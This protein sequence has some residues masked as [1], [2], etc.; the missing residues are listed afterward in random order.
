VSEIKIAISIPTYNGQVNIDLVDIFRRAHKRD[1]IKSAII[2]LPSS[3]IPDR[4]FNMHWCEALGA[5]DRGDAT[6]W[7]KYDP[8]ISVNVEFFIDEMVS[9]MESRRADIVS[10][11]TPIKDP[12]FNGLTSLAIDN[13][14]GAGWGI[15]RR[16][17]MD[18]VF[19]LPETFGNEICP[20][21]RLLVNNSLLLVDLRG[22]WCDNPEVKW[23]TENSIGRIIDTEGKIKRKVMC[24]PQDWYFSRV[25]QDAGASIVATRRISLE[26]YST[27]PLGF[28]SSRPWGTWKYDQEYATEPFKLPG[29]TI[30]TITP[31]MM[32]LLLKEPAPVG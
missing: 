10:A 12:T 17:T 21:R 19:D 32:T 25:A 7:L 27:T 23:H 14:T 6:H 16:L 30:E 29:K 15:E 4:N 24:V 31:E 18:E 2:P 5:R 11:I 26:H 20:G 9:V 28:T 13:E 22:D 8:D 1:D 3:S